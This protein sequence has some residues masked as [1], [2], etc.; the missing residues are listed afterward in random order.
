ME[1]SVFRGISG[2]PT[3]S[4]PSSVAR[5]C[6]RTGKDMI[7]DIS[8]FLLWGWNTVSV[9]GAAIEFIVCLYEGVA[10]L[11]GAVFIVHQCDDLLG[12]VD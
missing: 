12:D 3:S 6:A 8:P 5:S 2:F 4:P 7:E 9:F 11:W 10:A 1:P